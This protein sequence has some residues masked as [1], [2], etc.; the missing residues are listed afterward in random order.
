MKIKVGLFS[1]AIVGLFGF[2][3]LVAE[4]STR[5]TCTINC[6]WWN[7]GV[8]PVWRQWTNNI[9]DNAAYCSAECQHLNHPT[10]GQT[11]YCNMLNPDTGKMVSGEYKCYFSAN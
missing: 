3:G 5:G 9:M 10:L 1:T 7:D 4:Q 2:L 6:L 11:A 8:R